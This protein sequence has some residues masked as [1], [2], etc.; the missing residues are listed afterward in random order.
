[1]TESEKNSLLKYCR[2]LIL[3][4]HLRSEAYGM[5]LIEAAIHSKPLISCEIGTGTSFINKN[6]ET[7]FVVPP[8]NPE[9]LSIAINA[10][11]ENEELACSYGA[12]ARKRYETMFT[13]EIMGRAYLNLF[14]SLIPK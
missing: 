14:K 11:L 6:K 13:S 12:A 4:S 10:L 3:P 8:K 9:A 1:V 2:A 7:G 5:V